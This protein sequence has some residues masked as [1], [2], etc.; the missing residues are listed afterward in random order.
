MGLILLLSTLD[1][2]SAS[3]EAWTRRHLRYAGYTAEEMDN[4]LS[5]LQEYTTDLLERKERNA[6]LHE[7]IGKLTETQ[8]RR[9]RLYYFDDLTYSQIARTEGV[10][11]TSGQL[12]QHLF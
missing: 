4:L 11:R 10:F 8:S 7:A 2:I 6:R 12:G 1:N 9:L 3:G 5:S